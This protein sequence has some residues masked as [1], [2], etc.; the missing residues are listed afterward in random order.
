MELAQRNALERHLF[1][2]ATAVSA[3]LALMTVGVWILSYWLAD[4][5]GWNSKNWAV[6]ACCSQGLFLLVIDSSQPPYTNDFQVH[7]APGMVHAAG[8]AVDLPAGLRE[9][10]KDAVPMPAC[11]YYWNG[12][13]LYRFDWL[14]TVPETDVIIPLWAL[15]ATFLLLPI[16]RLRREWRLEV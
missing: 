3:V 8:A 9:S 10:V 11:C 6:R 5:V 15:V 12:F 4:E 14:S 13:G 16:L 7:F 2:S 1:R